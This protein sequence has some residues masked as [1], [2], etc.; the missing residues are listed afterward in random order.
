MITILLAGQ[1]RVGK[2][3]AATYIASYAK[4]QEYRPII[5]PFAQS[6]KDAAAAAGFSKETN[7]EEYRKYC[8]AEGEGRRKENPDH[9]INLFK[10][11]WLEL[12]KKDEQESQ[13]TDK[14]WKET[15]VI[16]DD[17][18]Y[19]NELNF[20]KSIGA[21][22][23]LI[24]KGSRTLAEANADWRKHESEDMANQYELGNKDYQD[25]F[26][27]VVKNEGTKEDFQHKLKDRLPLWLDAT[28]FSYVDCD[29][30]GCKKM[31]RDEKV[32]LEEFFKDLFGEEEEDD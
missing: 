13:S 1:A 30:A 11:K 27:F 19:L 8:Q 9:W 23:I 24:S 6:I 21:K 10:E 15:V 29:C 7:P 3:T 16:V 32:T 31:K 26:E 20:G 25:I 17:C 4:K 12:R 18:R 22:T 14:I 5:L 2:T 28:P